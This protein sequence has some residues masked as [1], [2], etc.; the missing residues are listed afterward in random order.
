MLNEKK[1]PII[2]DPVVKVARRWV[3]RDLGREKCSI[4][5]ECYGSKF[6]RSMVC[7]LIGIIN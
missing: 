2:S 1:K 6:K 7:L 4:A 5:T 3:I